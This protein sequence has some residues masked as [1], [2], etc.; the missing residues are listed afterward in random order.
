[1]NDKYFVFDLDG[2][3]V[4]TLIGITAAVNLTLKE[5]GID[6]TYNKDEVREFIGRGA[7]RLFTL[8]LNKVPT[9]DEFNLFLKNYEKCQYVSEEFE[10]VDETLKILN[11]KNIPIIVYS[12][13]P[14]DILKKL[15]DKLFPD[16]TF[17]Y[18]QGQDLSFPP[19]PDATLLNTFLKR[20][21]LK[22]ENGI[23][24][25]DS[26]VDILTADNALMKC[27]IVTYG[28]GDKKEMDL[29]SNKIYI[30]KFAKILD[31]ID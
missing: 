28:Y 12:N 17:F 8:A 10:G 25:G 22:N 14:D 6:K 20:A 7:K 1:M 11:S 19:K 9:E 21:H 30:D 29:E 23:F 26:V 2:T 27:I 3:L 16:V 13:K 4:D 18:I 15:L 31:Y 24:V 5:L